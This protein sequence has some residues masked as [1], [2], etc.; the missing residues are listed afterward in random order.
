MCERV[1]ERRRWGHEVVRGTDGPAGGYPAGVETET[2][3]EVAI[4]TSC[5]DRIDEAVLGEALAVLEAHGVAHYRVS[6]VGGLKIFVGIH[7]PDAEYESIRDELA[8]AAYGL[9]E[10]GAVDGF[11]RLRVGLTDS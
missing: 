11:R 5:R 1:G 2:V 8:D 6:P 10:H 4:P 9:R 3:S 7:R